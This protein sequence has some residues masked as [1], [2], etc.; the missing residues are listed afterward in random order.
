M[1][2]QPRQQLPDGIYHVTSRG[3]N[4][5]AIFVDDSDRKTF[6]TLLGSVVAKYDWTCHA[7]CLMT[8]HY[9]LIVETE[10][11]KLSR[12]M[13]V[14][15]GRYAQL[16][17]QRHGRD[18]HLFRSRYSVYVIDR[19][20]HFEASCLYVLENPVRAGLCETP[21]DW[22]WSGCPALAA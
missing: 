2:R 4:H 19:E 6:L 12:G 14:V 5:C 7:F 16:F 21:S 11:P 22:P 8:N 13:Q 1:P 17:N 9:H 3:T 10:Q 20:K 18:G 15:N